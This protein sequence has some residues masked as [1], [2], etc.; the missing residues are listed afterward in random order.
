MLLFRCWYC[1]KRY[2]MPEERIGQRLVCT[3]QR[4][5]RVPRRAGASSRDRTVVDWCVEFAVYGGG[6]ALLG[7]L[8][9]VVILSRVRVTRY[10]WLLIVG[11]TAAGFLAGGLGG[12]RAINWIGRM[13]REREQS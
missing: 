9:G 13:I 10:G 8:L 2:A 4:R 7:F 12:E 6:G 5:L 3:C 1:N 11:L